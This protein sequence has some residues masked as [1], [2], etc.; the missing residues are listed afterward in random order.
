VSTPA[1]AASTASSVVAPTGLSAWRWLIARRMTQVGLLVIFAGTARF[2]WEIAG[3]P[4]LAGN[5]SASTLLGI[6]PFADPF[7][8]LQQLLARQVLEQTVLVGAL[9]ILLVYALVLG[10]AWCAWVCPLNL[11]TDLAASLR[12]H[13]RV[14]DSLRMS[15]TV[16]YVA[17]A[18]SLVLS[19]VSGVAAFEWISPIGMMHR[20]L[21]LGLGLGWMAVLG[22]FLFD[23]LVLRHGW[24]GHLCPLG[25][26]YSLASSR[27]SLVK[28]AFDAPTCT[29]C[30]AC[31]VV[32]PEPQVLNLKKA[33]E[34]AMVASGE[35]TNCAQCIPVCPEGTLS[36]DL[37]T[38]IAR[39]R[40]TDSPTDERTS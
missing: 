37:R 4:L 33:A 34:A 18:L 32:C 10:R 22:V 29:H 2:G 20:E 7:A 11:V 40:E 3:R 8:V 31:A 1:P 19:A 15:R 28:I 26:F 6:V 35:C 9:I 12:R 36:F 5:L 38:R 24:C 13:L 17:L 39:R 25:A 27:S 21:I 23:L 14:T 16:R 30:G